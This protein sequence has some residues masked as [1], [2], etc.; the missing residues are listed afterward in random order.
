[1]T[2]VNLDK[3]SITSVELIHGY[4]N[5]GICE[6]MLDELT[7]TTISNSEDKV[8]ITGKGGRKINSLKKKK[9]V[10]VKGTNGVLCGGLLANQTG[11]KITAIN[12]ATSKVRVVETLIVN[13][14][15]ATT[16]ETAIGTAGNELVS[17][18]IKIG[19]SLGKEFTQVAATPTTGKFTYTPA[20]KEI[21]FFAGD[22]ADGTEIL[23]FY[24]KE[25]TGRVVTNPSDNY[26]KKV[27][28]Y[29]DCLASDSCDNLYHV[30]FEFPRADFNGTFDIAMGDNPTTQAFEFESL[31]GTCGSNG[32]LWNMT[33]FG[34]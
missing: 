17:L 6:F 29:M 11:G 28:I 34:A 27:K 1:M 16:S 31:A 8:D 23:V 10:T 3:L 33:V 15:K 7:E 19:D 12:G 18:N 25:I 14:N 5:A 21:T 30:Q 32:N 22:L 13:S 26:S 4:N 2:N 24:D 9:S 20:S